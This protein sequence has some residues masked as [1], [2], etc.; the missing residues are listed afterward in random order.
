MMISDNRFSTCNFSGLHINLRYQTH[1]K[2]LLFNILQ[3]ILFD[4]WLMMTFTQIF[5][6]LLFLFPHHILCTDHKTIHIYVYFS[7]GIPY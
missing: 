6:I 7:P 1:N 3:K 4:D 2:I 5:I